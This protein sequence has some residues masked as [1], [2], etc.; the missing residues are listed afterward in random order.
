M[1]QSPTASTVLTDVTGQ[2]SGAD[3]M[4]LKQRFDL[5]SSSEAARLLQVSRPTVLGWAGKGRLRGEV[6]AG[7]PYLR[8]ADVEALAAERAA[9]RAA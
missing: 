4:P 7:V 5:I 9:E 1:Q 3:A 8:R 2:Y 6:V